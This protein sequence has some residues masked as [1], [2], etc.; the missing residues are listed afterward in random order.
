M[1]HEDFA[2]WVVTDGPMG[3]RLPEEIRARLSAMAGRADLDANGDRTDRHER[4]AVPQVVIS[5]PVLT[6]LAD[7]APQPVRWLWPSRI[8]LGKLTVFAGR[9]DL[10]K[11]FITLDIAAQRFQ[12]RRLAGQPRLHQ[13]ARRRGLDVGGG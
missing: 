7:V 2:D 12:G 5:G 10:G 6:C 11:S 3:D 8:A 9:P 4:P 1:A 13:R